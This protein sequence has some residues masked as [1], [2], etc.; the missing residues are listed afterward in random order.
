MRMLALFAALAL[1]LLA[2]IGPARAGDPVAGMALFNNVPGAVLS[3]HDGSCHGPNP[4]DDLHGLQRGSNNAGVIDLAIR[5]LVPQMMFLAGLLS[6]VQL[7]D[8]AA[9]IAPQPDLSSTALAFDPRAVGFA[10]PQQVATLA[11][12]G[13]VNLR[14][15]DVSV[16]GPNTADFDV[17]G[18]CVTGAD[19]V[20]ATSERTGGA[21]EVAVSFRPTATGPRSAA[22]KLTYAGV[23]TFPAFQTI[24]LTGTGA[25]AGTPQAAFAPGQIDFGEVTRSMPSPSQSVT[26]TN[27]GDAPL[28]VSGASLSGPQADEFGLSGTCLAGPLPLTLGPGASCAFTLAFTPQG[29][30]VRTAVLNVQHDAAGSPA[31][32]ALRGVGLAPTCAPPLPPTE[33]QTL[34]CAPGY[35][36]SITQS[37]DPVCSG[38]TW[39]PGPWQTVADNCQPNIPLAGLDLSEY[40]NRDLNHYFV[41]ADPAESANVE[42]GGA[43]PGWAR[44]FALGGV[45]RDVAAA[46]LQPV[47]RFYGNTALGSD[48]RRRGPNSHFYTVDPV[49]CAAVKKDAGWIF[50][51]IVF[52]AVPAEDGACPPPLTPVYRNYNG[53]FRENDS[54]HRYT[55]NPAIVE[56]MRA[57]G[58]ASEGV[59]FCIA[60]L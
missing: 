41:T 32:V 7:E 39:S 40:F 3:C 27:P 29:L 36:G 14:L 13:G 4:N 31:Q 18:S 25:A 43:G 16:G 37:R 46:G 57:Q 34:A 17:G 42:S 56:I 1:G 8:L 54:N 35:S 24:A 5:K 9:Y 15:A 20:S 22:V 6:P 55:T 2:G 45:W 48:G 47:C 49:E 44:T 21:C 33:F 11:N 38:T 50:E 23:A 12:P 30:G 53:R 58:W 60:P 28:H 26:L 19:L 59:V 52:E 10:S 51:G